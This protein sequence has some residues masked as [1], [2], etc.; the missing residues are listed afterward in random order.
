MEIY[1]KINVEKNA[2]KGYVDN[3]KKRGGTATI[4]EKNGK[5]I[6]EYYF[7]D[8]NNIN[9][10]KSSV[11]LRKLNEQEYD[12]FISNLNKAQDNS[13][14]AKNSYGNKSAVDKF[15]NLKTNYIIRSINNAKKL[16]VYVFYNSHEGIIY[17]NSPVGQIS[18]HQDI[19]IEKFKNIIVDDNNYEWDGI[20]DVQQK[21]YFLEKNKEANI[22]T[23]IKF[24][25][26]KSK[27]MK[28]EWMKK[29]YEEETKRL[30]LFYKNS[31]Q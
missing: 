28:I 20:R 26:N 18:F 10:Y 5:Y 23:Y 7:P 11:H 22:S 27:E 1:S 31:I 13:T 25:E 4:K 9:I 14:Q 29:G 17:F 16:G 30:I 19:N 3:I 6:V 12:K 21:L 24:R 8:K 15:Y 2:I